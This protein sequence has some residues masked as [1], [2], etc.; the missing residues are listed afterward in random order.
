[1]TS[2]LTTRPYLSLIQQAAMD[3]GITIE[4]IEPN[5]IYRLQTPRACWL[6]MGVDPGLNDSTAFQLAKSKS[7]TYAVLSDA[8]VP[9][10]PH[11]FLNHPDAPRGSSSVF[12]KAE[13]WHKYY[14]SP[15]VVKPDDGSQGRQVSLVENVNQLQQ[16]LTELFIRS[17]H[18]ALS[19][20]MEGKY[21]YRIVV[22]DGESVFGFAKIQPDGEWRHNLVHGAKQKKSLQLSYLN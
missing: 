15:V 19:P 17:Q 20:F 7:A 4:A 13:K 3:E 12:G 18:A 9:A 10:V 1:M 16:H 14:D 22:L 2:P 11:H 5:H 21:E 8:K 6:M